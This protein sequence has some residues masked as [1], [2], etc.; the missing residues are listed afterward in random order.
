MTG[1]RGQSPRGRP[2]A[3]AP[4]VAP[5]RAETAWQRRAA[6]RGQDPDLFFPKGWGALYHAQIERAMAI[7]DG[8][9]VRAA[10]LSAALTMEHGKSIAE[11]AGIWGG[12]TA[13]ERHRMAPSVGLPA[14]QTTAS[15]RRTEVAHFAAYHLAE[16]EIADRLGL[17]R[18]YVHSL[19]RVIQ[20]P[21]V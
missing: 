12:A 16:N 3:S 11:R 21:T 8:C 2:Y 1:R 6:C 19:L 5:D 7:C 15:E 14:P 18:G 20:G 9:P 4:S 10:C 17:T 13:L